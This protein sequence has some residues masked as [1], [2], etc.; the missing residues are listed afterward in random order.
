MLTFLPRRYDTPK[1][2]AYV[3]PATLAFAF[4]NGPVIH[5]LFEL[6]QALTSVSDESF[7]HHLLDGRHDIADWVNHIIGDKD[8]A[9]VLKA[10]TH[11]WGMVVALERQQMRTLNF[12]PYLAKRWLKTAISP[13]I[14][15]NGQQA[16]TLQELADALNSVPD[17]VIDFHFQRVPNDIAAWVAES[18]GDYELAEMLAEAANRIQLHQLVADR[19]VMLQDAVSS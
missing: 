17:D 16:H 5:S 7:N 1:W 8:L 2:Q 12:P 13:F 19:V 9:D 10:Q 6:K 18:V 14:F 15:S 11:R 4:H 3:V